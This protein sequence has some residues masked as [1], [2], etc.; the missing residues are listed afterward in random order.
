[1]YKCQIRYC[2]TA[3]E[4]V[5]RFGRVWLCI[6]HQQELISQHRREEKAWA[7]KKANQEQGLDAEAR[8]VAEEAC[9]FVKPPEVRPYRHVSE[10]LGGLPSLG[11]KQ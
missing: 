7:K 2:P 1:M 8:D 10:V 11:K 9:G 6:N 4:Q 5:E 3:T